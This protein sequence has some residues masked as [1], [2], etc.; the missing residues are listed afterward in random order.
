MVLDRPA[1]LKGQVGAPVIGS[2][3]KIGGHDEP[4]R[5]RGAGCGLRVPTEATAGKAPEA[6]GGLGG[7]VTGV[8]IT[9]KSPGFRYKHGRAQQPCGVLD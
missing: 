6:E 3:T 1:P 7:G 9:A 4:A 2:A 8:G 5:L